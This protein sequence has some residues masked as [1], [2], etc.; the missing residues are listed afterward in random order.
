MGI[1]SASTRLLTN[2]EDTSIPTQ[3][4][5]AGIV[6]QMGTR[7]GRSV[8]QTLPLPGRMVAG[9]RSELWIIGLLYYM[10][11]PQRVIS[12]KWQVGFDT[13]N[14]TGMSRCLA[15]APR[16]TT[17]PWRTNYDHIFGRTSLA[18]RGVRVKSWIVLIEHKD[19]K[20]MYRV[21]SESPSFYNQSARPAKLELERDRGIVRA[22]IV[23]RGTWVQPE[24]GRAA[25]RLSSVEAT[26]RDRDL[27]GRRSGNEAKGRMAAP[28]LG[29]VAH[30]YDRAD[31]HLVTAFSIGI[32][33]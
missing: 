22:W 31:R 23:R 7:P 28:G 6:C 16:T 12:V 18:I 8:E 29:W 21:P 17:G 2:S 33:T 30:N 26:G 20:H 13:G 11:V 15:F 9:R 25:M 4:R 32:A 1:D 3:D 19:S 10:H 14:R 27:M 24:C 5:G